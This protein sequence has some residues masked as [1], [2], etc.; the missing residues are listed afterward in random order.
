MPPRASVVEKP[1]PPPEKQPLQVLA[2]GKRANAEP[3][4]SDASDAE[5][6]VDMRSDVSEDLS[7]DDASSRESSPTPVARNTTNAPPMTPYNKKT[8][9]DNNETP[10]ILTNPDPKYTI[11]HNTGKPKKCPAAS[12]AHTITHIAAD[13]TPAPSAI[14]RLHHITSDDS[15]TPLT[16]GSLATSIDQLNDNLNTAADMFR[17]ADASTNAR[18]TKAFRMMDKDRSMIRAIH[19]ILC[20]LA[21]VL[22][23]DENIS[24]LL[25]PID[26]PAPAEP[27]TSDQP[28]PPEPL[29]L[30]S[31][32]A[33]SP[34]APSTKEIDYWKQRCLNAERE[35]KKHRIPLPV[36]AP[37]PN[38]ESSAPWKEAVPASTKLF[39][40]ATP[41]PPKQAPK[42][43]QPPKKNPPRPN[44]IIIPC[45]DPRSFPDSSKIAVGV[46]VNDALCKAN[47]PESVS[48][49]T[50]KKNINGNLILTPSPQTTP[51]D[52]TPHLPLI[53][54]AACK[55]HPALLPPRI[56]EKWYKLAVHGVPIDFFPDSTE[57]MQSLQAEIERVNWG[58]SRDRR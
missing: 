42:P 23:P 50:V 15:S 34:E 21:P 12:T 10:D 17:H 20:C 27:A 4:E 14:K 57:G 2:K 48:I 26:L 53:L 37:R 30:P 22:L 9:P 5:M 43:S 38:P 8:L 28:L 52:I 31:V 29:D 3:Q 40:G 46:A 18:I 16:T 1:P 13:G 56:N 25:P 11:Q 32:H 45:P 58:L 47:A 44:D 6:H 51:T 54:E 39:S 36:H 41:T 7:D 55:V 49:S 35:L 19:D 33:P 24:T